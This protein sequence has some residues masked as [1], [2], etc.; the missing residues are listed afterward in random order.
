MKHIKLLQDIP[1]LR[2]P[3][4]IAAFSGWNDASEVATWSARFLVR[5]WGAVKFAEVEPEEYY[6]F[7]ETRPTVK[8]VGPSMR[9]IE[10][11][12]NELYYHKNPKEGN[13]Y[14]V[15]VGV[16]PQL[17]WQT[18]VEEL[19][20]VIKQ[21]RVSCVITLG[22]LLAAV[23]HSAPPRI[24]GTATDPRFQAPQNRPR[25]SGYQG[26]TGIL[27]VINSSCNKENISTASIWGNVPHY[28]QA[29]P[30][31]RVASAV[32]ERLNNVLSLN[33]DLREPMSLATKFDRKVSELVDGNPE[34][35]AYVKQLEEEERLDFDED[36]GTAEL[37]EEQPSTLSSE[38]IM[39]ELEEFF[40]QGP[41]E[42]EGPKT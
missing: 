27:G 8:I 14:V 9:S 24:T 19:T 11:P 35:A 33:L 13:D 31:V 42:D 5:K 16:E 32:L 2:D 12:S 40:K 7:T 36:N 30:N 18:F 20:D 41:D 37:Q 1:S 22:G 3:V 23:P 4:L 6:V 28:L 38:D 34:V 26:P 39:Q 25:P 10:W 21:L 29:S 17:K 15:F